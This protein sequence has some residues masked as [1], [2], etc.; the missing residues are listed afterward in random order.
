MGIFFLVRRLLS[1][2]RVAGKVFD[3]ANEQIQAFLKRFH[4]NANEAKR[5][6]EQRNYGEAA[7]Y[8]AAW[9][10]DANRRHYSATK[11]TEIILQLAESLRRMGDGEAAL[12][13]AKE[14]LE[15]ARALGAQHTLCGTALETLGRVLDERGEPGAALKFG[16]EALEVALYNR[17]MASC[18]ERASWLAGLERKAG[19]TG[20][21]K[22][23]LLDSIEYFT[24]AHGEH[25]AGTASQLASMGIAMQEEGQLA[26]ALPLFEKAYAVHRE[27][28][29]PNASA[30]LVDLEHMGQIRYLQGNLE[31]AVTLYSRLAHLKETE[32]GAGQIEH[33][34]LLI[35][36]ATVHEVA[37]ETS[38]AL[39]F[40]MQAN[41]KCGRDATLA[42]I[43][44]ERVARLRAV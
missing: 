44:A 31:E 41:Q 3:W 20:Q 43:I 8:C 36:A 10:D 15:W 29:G 42:P 30:T 18:A 32:I 7:K 16:R 35:D 14:A 39:E 37:G 17:E 12:K 5:N 24:S 38:K 27:L 25:H 26:E 2:M 19:H 23:L 9:L 21:A 1:T 11:K 6:F 22:Q 13:T 40:L 33:G 4:A 28:L 34:R